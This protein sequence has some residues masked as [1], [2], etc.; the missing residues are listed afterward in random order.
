MKLCM[1][2]VL[3][4]GNTFTKFGEGPMHGMHVARSQA[5]HVA[6]IGPYFET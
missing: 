6:N 3:C 2:V 5:M 1:I 4:K